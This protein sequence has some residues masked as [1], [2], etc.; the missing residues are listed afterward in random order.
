MNFRELIEWSGY[1]ALA[2]SPDRVWRLLTAGAVRRVKLQGNIGD[3]PGYVA[4]YLA[5]VATVL[6]RP[7]GVHFSER[8]YDRRVHEAREI[9]FER[10]TSV[11]TLYMYRRVP[12]LLTA[13]Q[14]VSKGGSEDRFSELSFPRGML[15]VD[16]LL[17]E[18]TNYCS[19]LQRAAGVNHRFRVCSS[20]GSVGRN[21]FLQT[22]AT[23]KPIDPGE[24][25]PGTAYGFN[26]VLGG[27][28]D[29]LGAP[30]V[31]TS[32]Q[33]MWW[34]PEATLLRDDAKR[35]RERQT[36]CAE[37]GM[38]WRRGWLL[39]G[40]PGNGKTQT[41]RAIAEELDLPIYAL[42]V[43]TMN[44]D[45]FETEYAQ[46]CNRAPSIVLIEDL[47]ATFRM[48]NGEMVNTVSDQGVSFNTLLNCLSGVARYQG[49]IVVFTTNMLKEVDVA[50]CQ[51]TGP[52]PHEVSRPDRVD[53]C[54]EFKRPTE[55]G[56]VVIAQR[57]LRD[58]A[59]ALALAKSTEGFTIAQVQDA[60]YREAKTLMELP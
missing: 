44:C 5:K 22:G 1:G 16:T 58:D 47:H 18:A 37:R 27:S 38:P 14:V 7:T 53:L 30:V 49:N 11:P 33:W 60:C 51:P 25:M 40:D 8:A 46:A 15:D 10:L 19:A 13:H 41:V 55:D 28:T 31:G 57:I 50:L 9:V 34:S 43:A 35:W 12:V 26:R 52:Q 48:R 20:R 56:R 6:W 4:R 21:Q 24:S 42:N 39:H 17:I 32:A 45:E 3:L 29:D 54:V 36:W 59:R 23:I 2:A